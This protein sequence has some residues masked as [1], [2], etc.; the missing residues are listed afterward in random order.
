MD[1]YVRSKDVPRAPLISP[2]KV[3]FANLPQEYELARLIS[4]VKTP[5]SS[6]C[7]STAA[8]SWS[9]VKCNEKGQVSHICWNEMN[10]FGTLHL[11]YL[12]QTLSTFE[13]E[14]S[15]LSGEILL[16]NLPFELIALSLHKNYFTGSLDLSALPETM[17]W[18]YLCWNRFSG[19]VCLNMLPARLEIINVHQNDLTGTPDLTSLPKNLFELILVLV[20]SLEKTFL[21]QR[22]TRT[23]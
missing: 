10:L 15:Q 16:D 12:P 22:I 3:G 9:D 4:D 19:E 6:W 1:L 17:K 14:E 13:V 18:V 23:P 21:K 8:C 5:H 11:A 2:A 7:T 20:L